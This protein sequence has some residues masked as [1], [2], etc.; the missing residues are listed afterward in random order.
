MYSIHLNIELSY[1]NSKKFDNV[2]SQYKSH[3]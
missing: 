3:E 2:Q 1:L